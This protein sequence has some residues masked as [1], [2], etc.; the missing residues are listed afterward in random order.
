M[1]KRFY[2]G[3]KDQEDLDSL[4]EWIAARM[5]LP[6][7]EGTECEDEAHVGDED[8]WDEELDTTRR[9][10]ATTYLYRIED[11]HVCYTYVCEDCGERADDEYL[12]DHDYPT[13]PSGYAVVPKHC[14]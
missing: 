10:P 8:K 7:P 3:K 12:G 1:S 6:P 11:G 4:E 2:I 14:Q 5:P 13:T 9:A